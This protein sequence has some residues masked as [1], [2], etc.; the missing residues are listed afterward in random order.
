MKKKLVVVFALMFALSLPCSVY[1][2]EEGGFWGSSGNKEDG[3]NVEEFG[4]EKPKDTAE[5]ITNAFFSNFLASTPV[6]A[7][8]TTEGKTY[9]NAGIIIKSYG[10]LDYDINNDGTLEIH[11]DAD[12]IH[13]IAAYLD[14][15]YSEL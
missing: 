15:L 2:A 13:K 10:V 5:I 7:S 6:V 1:A 14:K 9:T 4:T 11:F 12:D 3:E 8:V